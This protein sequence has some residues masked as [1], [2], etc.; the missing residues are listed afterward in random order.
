M[1]HYRYLDIIKP[2]I[3]V[4]IRR[5]RNQPASQC[6]SRNHGREGPTGEVSSTYPPPTH[7]LVFI[8]SSRLRL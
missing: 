1:L 7:F 4:F 2:T 8:A 5:G 6:R 3:G